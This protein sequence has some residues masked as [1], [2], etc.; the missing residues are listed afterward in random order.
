MAIEHTNETLKSVIKAY[1]VRGVVG[2][3]I[4]E[5]FVR[6]AGAAFAHILRGEGETRI[7]VSYTHLTLPTTPYV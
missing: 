4:D 3:T 5:D 1:D 6:T 7:A 2:E